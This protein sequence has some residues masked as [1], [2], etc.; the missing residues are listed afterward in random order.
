M[1]MIYWILT[2]MILVGSIV[3]SVA[4]FPLAILALIGGIV[5]HSLRRVESDPPSIAVVTRFG[6]RLW[7]EGFDEEEKPVLVPVIKKEGWRLFWFYPYLYGFIEIDVSKKNPDFKSQKVMCPDKA[8]IEIPLSVTYTPD[9]NN[10]I[11]FLNSGKE[12]GVEDILQDIVQQ[13]LREWAIATE[14]G[15]Q[16]W[17]EAMAAKD[18]AIWLL[19][20]AIL[21]EE[22]PTIKKSDGTPSE[23]PSIFWRQYFYTS[24]FKSKPKQKEDEKKERYEKRLENWKEWKERIGAE[25]GEN[26]EN[27]ASIKEQI[28]ARKNEI[29]EIRRG[30][31]CKPIRHLGIILKRLNLGEFKLLGEVAKAAEL[32]VKEEREA[33]A[34]DVEIDNFNNLVKKIVK[35]TGVSAEEA[36]RVV[37]SERKKLTRKE[38]IISGGSGALA[39]N[40]QSAA[41]TGAVLA[42]TMK[43]GKGN[44]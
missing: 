27:E 37:Q 13:K 44:E 34:E 18:D 17:E 19:S 7:K 2:V 14:E 12:S 41:V 3:I 1:K 16:T 42:E 39:Q 36:V 40:A 5:L 25:L 8:E 24:Y 30:N 31:G 26:K 15:P 28:E 10:I 35:E 38:F 32:K 23:I 6:N 21:G 22:L 9:S 43:G 29:E 20:K 11:N 33:L 4:L